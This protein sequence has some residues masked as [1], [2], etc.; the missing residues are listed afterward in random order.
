VLREV[1]MPMASFYRAAANPAVDAL[2]SAERRRTSG[3]GVPLFT[4]GMRGA[5]EALIYLARGGRVGMLI[6]QKMNDGIESRLFGHPAM[7][8][9]AAASLAL[10]I[11]CP[12]VPGH[13]ER[14]GPARLRIVVEPPLAH[15]P[16]G[17]PHA[18]IAALTQAMNDC[19][20]RWI[21]ARPHEW[22][23]LHRRF[24]QEVYRR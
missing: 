1:G 3:E 9:P 16:C 24:P 5:R 19:L 2:I 7:T 11:G 12:L 14:I 18:D 10:R 4:K 20:E 17:D 15:S 13:V 22:L 8:A 6:D 23:W 21:R